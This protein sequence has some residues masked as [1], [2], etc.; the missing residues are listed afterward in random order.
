MPEL[1]FLLP[2]FAG[3]LKLFYPN[4]RFPGISTSHSTCTHSPSPRCAQRVVKFTQAAIVSTVAGI[5]VLLGVPS[6]GIEPA[7]RCIGGSLARR[8]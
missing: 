2:V 3:I 8:C 5:I 4:R 1:L 6:T 7:A